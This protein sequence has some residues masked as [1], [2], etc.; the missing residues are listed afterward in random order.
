MPHPAEDDHHTLAALREVIT[1]EQHPELRAT[2]LREL[3]ALGRN[4][5]GSWDVVHE[6]AGI[7]LLRDALADPAAS[8]RAAAVDVLSERR[9]ARDAATTRA[10]YTLIATDEGPQLRRTAFRALVAATHEGFRPWP[11]DP[12]AIAWLHEY[13]AA[14]P[15]ADSRRY[16]L[17]L[18]DDFPEIAEVRALLGEIAEQHPDDSV[19]RTVVTRLGLAGHDD[20]KAVLRRLAHTD[21]ADEVRACAVGALGCWGAEFDDAEA[22]RGTELLRDIEILREVAVA[23]SAAI[24][25][26]AAWERLAGHTDLPQVGALLLRRAMDDPDSDVRAQLLVDLADDAQYADDRAP[27]VTYLTER[28]EDDADPEVRQLAAD[29]VT[30]LTAGAAHFHKR[31]V[32][33]RYRWY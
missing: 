14:D 18:L 22:I 1:T 15:C 31:P 4:A 25:R 12:E 17:M 13:V 7:D 9:C 19:R 30:D 6:C 29:L 24:V 3:G 26:G 2:A 27:A 5:D 16:A 28:A 21:Q 8:V 23:D 11:D 32:G 33:T 20:T 10:L